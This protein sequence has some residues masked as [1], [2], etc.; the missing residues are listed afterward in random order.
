M[1]A[2]AGGHI[3]INGLYWSISRH[4]VRGVV[5]QVRNRLAKLLAELR[6]VTPQSGSLPEP[7]DARAAVNVVLKGIGTR[8]TINTISAGDDSVNSI[9]STTEGGEVPGWSVGEGGQGDVGVAG[10]V[11][12]IAVVIAIL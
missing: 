12:A 4:A 3:H 2:E 8:A 11:G 9:A 5:E 10:V 1:E 7:D 6:S